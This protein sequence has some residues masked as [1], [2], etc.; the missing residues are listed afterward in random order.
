MSREQPVKSVIVIG[1]RPLSAADVVAVAR[2]G[3]R[4]SL[5]PAARRR[6]ERSRAA[7]DSA[8]AKG[9][10]LY[11]VNTGFGRL[12]QTRVSAEDLS[13]LQLNLIRSHAA[14]TGAPL[15][16]DVVRAILLLRAAS[17]SWGYSGVRPASLDTL[18]EAINR[19]LIPVVPSRGS[20]GASGDLAP[21]AHITLAL[22]GE[23][24]FR[25]RGRLLSGKA[26]LARARLQPLSLREKEGLAF[27]NGTQAHTAL[28]LLALWDAYRL[29]EA[30]LVAGAISTEAIQGS[31]V[32]FSRRFADVRP[33]PGHRAAAA[34][35]ASYLTGSGIRR[36]HLHCER[37]QDPYSFRCQPQVMGAVKDALDY[38]RGA[39]L[40]EINSVTDNPLVDAGRGQVYSGG[41]FH[42]QP[43]AM[44]LDHLTLALTT[45]ANLSERRLAALMDPTQS[46]LPPFL[47]ARPGRDSGLMIWQVTAAALASENKTSASPASCDTIPTSA[48][49]EDFVCMGMGAALKARA[50]LER[51]TQV[52]AIEL[53]AGRFG[54]EHRKPLSCGPRLS[55]FVRRLRRAVPAMR[56]DRNFQ[57]DFRAVHALVRSGFDGILSE[58]SW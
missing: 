37:V 35:L 10:V 16:D 38:A 31:D 3:S 13:A 43:V 28:G 58:E 34:R 44:V 56:A 29:W 27:I 40:R 14:G 42:G 25:Y 21:L 1:G 55:P 12:A 50:A 49:Q 20:V 9:R 53:L 48:N 2:G 8:L 26:A 22:L 52:V 4:V 17:L 23:G 51:S 6:V 33:H 36:A 39:L 54:I 45:L 11:G 30:A 19:G 47:A 46:G 24:R 15:P 5:A 32:P 18:V 57:E 7:L 41:N